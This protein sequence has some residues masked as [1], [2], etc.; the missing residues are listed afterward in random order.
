MQM[1]PLAHADLRIFL[2]MTQNYGVI[3]QVLY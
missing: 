2:R 3:V 1:N